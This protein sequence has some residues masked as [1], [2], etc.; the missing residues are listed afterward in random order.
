MAK[1]VS[2]RK[3]EPGNHVLKAFDSRDNLVLGDVLLESERDIQRLRNQN[4][5]YVIL[6]GKS[7]KQSDTDESPVS[8]STPDHNEPITDV[9]KED[10]EETEGKL[11]LSEEIQTYRNLFESME[12]IFLDIHRGEG[13]I[14]SLHDLKPHINKFVDFMEDS[15]AYLSILTQLENYDSTT[16]NH[17]INVCIFSLLY[18]NERGFTSERLLDLA[19]G[20][21]VHD[22]GKTRLPQELLNKRGTLTDEEFRKIK[23]HPSAGRDL[24]KDEVKSEVWRISYEHHERPSGN[25]YPRGTTN[26]DMN[27]KIVS[28]IDVYEALTAPRSYNSTLLPAKAFLV[29]KDEF[30]DEPRTRTIWRNLVRSL[31]LFSV[32]S[33]VRLSNGMIGVVVKNNLENLE[34]PVVKVILDDQ[35]E[36]VDTPFR[37]NLQ[38][39]QHQKKLLNNYIFDDSIHIEQAMKIEQLRDLRPKIQEVVN[40]QESGM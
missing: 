39:I 36:P 31:C 11:D 35:E 30:Y 18:G 2:I 16:Y 5:R 40:R 22:I 25:G 23:R 1:R 17:S 15:P 28:V 34:T 20:A 19:F 10:Q 24:L 27:S 14:E 21:L 29:M 4:V 26:I 38:E 37:I 13:N 6:S 12:E 33:F 32:G 8:E 9:E 3:L 7:N